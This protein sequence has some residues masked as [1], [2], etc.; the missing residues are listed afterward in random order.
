MLP[1][2]ILYNKI[3]TS[4][5]LCLYVFYYLQSITSLL[6]SYHFPKF[7]KTSSLEQKQYH[8]K[9]DCEN[10]DFQIIFQKSHS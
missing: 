9:L 10:Q 5:T 8:S 1:K 7:G 6:K 4:T 3:F 2:N